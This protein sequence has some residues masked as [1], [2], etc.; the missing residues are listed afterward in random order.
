MEDNPLFVLLA[1]D[2]KD[3]CFLFQLVLEELQLNTQLT[4]VHDGEKLMQ[5]L[6]QETNK[7]PTVLF[8]DLNMPRKNGFESL[9]EIKLNE[10]LKHIPVIIFST[11]FE[12]EMADLLYKNGANFYI[13]KPSEFSELTK[14]IYHV[15]TISA[16][17][18]FAQPTKDKFLLTGK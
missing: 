15:L 12:Q 1:D 14:V 17:T 16:K 6:T 18:N 10:K 4:T 11:S 9:V 3:D 13:R 7:P 8:L 5:L 2:D